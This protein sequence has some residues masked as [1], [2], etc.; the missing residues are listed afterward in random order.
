MTFLWYLAVEVKAAEEAAAKQKAEEEAAAARAKV[1]ADATARAQAA[2]EA[3]APQRDLSSLSVGELRKL[4]VVEGVPADEIEDAR[5]SFAPKDALIEL[6]EARRQVLEAT[7]AANVVKDSAPNAAGSRYHIDDEPGPNLLPGAI[8]DT[9]LV[10]APQPHRMGEQ[11]SMLPNNLLVPSQPQIMERGY[12]PVATP[13]STLTYRE[14]KGKAG[15]SKR[16]QPIGGGAPRLLLKAEFKGSCWDCCRP[17]A[18]L[19][20]KYL[21]RKCHTAPRVCLALQSWLCS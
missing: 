15:T 1:E 19:K 9:T 8:D 18:A 21:Y 17:E 2:E 6:I 4:A 11:D 16:I 3:M 10:P 20:R 7:A 14:P 12:P 5:D 13:M